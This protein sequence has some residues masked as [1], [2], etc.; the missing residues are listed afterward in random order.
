MF[1]TLKKLFWFFKKRKKNYIIGVLVLQLANFIIIFPPIIIGKTIDSIAKG[2]ITWNELMTYVGFMVVLFTSEYICNFTWSYNVFSNAIVI[3]FDLRNMI[4]NKILSMPRPFFEKFSSGDLMSRA[5]SDVTTISDLLGYGTMAFSDGICYLSTVIIAMG[6]I[7]SWKLTFFSI[8]PL[9][10]L[11]LFSNY[12]GHHIHNEYTKQQEAFSTMSDVALENINGLRVVRSYVLENQSIANFEKSITDVYKKSLR[13]EI[14]ADIFW[15]SSKIFTSLSYAIAIWYGS[16]LIASGQI[17]LGEL[18]S[19]NIYLGFLV[20]P[21]FSI[22]D[23]I[24]IAQRASTSIERIYEVLEEKDDVTQE[25]EVKLK[26]DV[27]CDLRFENYTFKYPTS[28]SNNLENI[29]LFIP[30]GNTLGIVGKTGSGK[31]TLIKQVL[32]EYEYGSGDVLLGNL[33]LKNIEVSSLMS[34][35]GYVPQDSILFSKTIKENILIGKNDADDEK[36]ERA[37]YLAG[38]T[39]DISNFSKGVNTLVGERGVS[40]SGGQKQRISIARAL[41]KEPDILILD[42]SLSAVDSKTQMNIIQ[43][44]RNIRKNKSTIIVSHRLSLVSHAQEIIVMNDGKIVERG[45]HE[46]LMEQNGWYA[47]Q[48]QTQQLKEDEQND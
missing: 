16:S 44:I 33:S 13:T 10:F 8:L 7:I 1:K 11:V 2:T 6:V 28:S 48:Y 12:L 27:P 24:N 25:N 17:T 41:L 35:I 45:N 30:E 38:L 47:A 43:N 31:S 4:M 21:M 14:I 5:T 37:I 19:F 34:K 22:G 15:P 42:D 36:I 18:I 3:D 23:F 39:K 32:K 40:I 20:W 26:E 29:D 9:P 46:N